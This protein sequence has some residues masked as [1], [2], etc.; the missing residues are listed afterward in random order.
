MKLDA[1]LHKKGPVG[2]KKKRETNKNLKSKNKNKI[3]KVKKKEKKK[4]PL[5]DIRRQE[6][7][8]DAV[9]FVFCY[10]LS[11]GMKPT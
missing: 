1:I 2:L 11:L 3:I 6:I 7:S 5:H 8:K 4:K 10:H 9:Q